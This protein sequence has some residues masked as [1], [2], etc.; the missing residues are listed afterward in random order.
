M[1]PLPGAHVRA[2]WHRQLGPYIQMALRVVE[3]AAL[4]ADV[5]CALAFLVATSVDF[6][7]DLWRT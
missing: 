2:A 6:W 1:P 3:I 5:F 4:A 7:R